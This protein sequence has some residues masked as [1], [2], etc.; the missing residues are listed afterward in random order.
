MSEHRW[1]IRALSSPQRRLMQPMDF[2]EVTFEFESPS[3]GGDDTYVISR[4]DCIQGPVAAAALTFGDLEIIKTVDLGH[5][6]PHIGDDILREAL[7]VGGAHADEVLTEAVVD[8]EDDVLEYFIEDGRRSA[9]ERGVSEFPLIC[10]SY[11]TQPV[12][13]WIEVHRPALH[14]EIR[15]A[16]SDL[17]AGVFRDRREAE[18]DLT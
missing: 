1:V 11:K 5:I 3:F 16:I 9:I 4:S 7:T 15:N 8:L 12:L 18:P 13:D 2:D 14:A 6:L 10:L 17:A